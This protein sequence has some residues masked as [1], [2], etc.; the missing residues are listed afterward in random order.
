MFQFLLSQAQRGAKLIEQKKYKDAIALFTS[1]VE[2]KSELKDAHYYLGLC[3]F[4]SGDYPEAKKH[5]HLALDLN[6]EPSRITEI[7]E[8][9]NWNMISSKEYYNSCQD[10]SPDGSHIIFSCAKKDS[11]GDGK[12]N[13]TDNRGI[14]LTDIVTGTEECL[15]TDDCMNLRPVFSLDGK[16][17]A[18]ISNKNNI[19]D[20]AGKQGLFIID[21]ESRVEKELAPE[22]NVKYHLFSRDDSKIYFCGWKKGDKNN[23]I[24]S[25]GINN[26]SLMTLVPGI[27]DNAFPSLSPAGDKLLYTSWRADTN[28]DGIIDFH[29]NSGIYIK[30]L[31]DGKEDEL[32]SAHFNNTFPVFD[33]DGKTILYLSVRR[34]TNGDG[35]ADVVWYTPSTGA[36]TIWPGAVKDLH[37]PGTVD[38][39]DRLEP[40]ATQHDHG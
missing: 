33:P 2:K 32:V 19:Q 11:N 16:K 35:L 27:Y 7:L 17:V 8:L 40:F 15:V 24:Y 10:F 37:R 14:Y 39:E 4:E 29:D 9:V 18:Y 28:G 12:I 26:E 34:D 5:F 38:N 21:L 3:F 1:L 31:L 25:I 22:Y 30:N 20:D 36:I 23:G 13:S 6:Q